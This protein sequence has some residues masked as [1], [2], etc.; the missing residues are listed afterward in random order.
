MFH[1]EYSSG[2]PLC[3]LVDLRTVVDTALAKTAAAAKTDTAKSR[4]A[5]AAASATATPEFEVLG[6]SAAADDD[7]PDRS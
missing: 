3:L 5:G 7:S 6:S 2:Q 4:A 1:A